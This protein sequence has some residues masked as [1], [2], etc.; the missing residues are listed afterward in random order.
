[1][2]YEQSDERVQTLWLKLYQVGMS[3]ADRVL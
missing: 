3:Q 2:G 1:M